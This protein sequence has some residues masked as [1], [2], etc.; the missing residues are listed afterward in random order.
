MRM[1]HTLDV[2]SVVDNNASVREART[3][4]LFSTSDK[5][6]PVQCADELLKSNRP[7]STAC[8]IADMQLPGVTGLELYQHL[9]ASGKANPAI[10]LTS[11]PG[12]NHWLRAL[13]ADVSYSLVKPFIDSELLAGIKSTVKSQTV[14]GRQS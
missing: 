8:L 14:H 9:A 6:E 5:P 10:L 13:R 2:I 1:P 11:R 12:D 4:V 7:V 3:G